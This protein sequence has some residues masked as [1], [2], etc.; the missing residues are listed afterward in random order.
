MTRSL[1]DIAARVD[2]LESRAR[3]VLESRSEAQLLWQPSP[4]RWGLAQVFEHLLRTHTVYRPNLQAALNAAATTTTTTFVPGRMARGFEW[5]A[6][7]RVRVRLPA[8]PFFEPRDAS[9]AS[10]DRFLAEWDVFRG[11]VREAQGRDL[12][13]RVRMPVPVLKLGLGEALSFLTGHAERHV[14][15]AERVVAAEGFPA[16]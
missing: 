4:E 13:A 8:P 14:A 11:I 1:G 5:F 2:A 9:P 3:D 15:Q 10:G 12:R 16:A 6:S 7:E